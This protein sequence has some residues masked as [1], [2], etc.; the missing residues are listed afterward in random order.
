MK[1]VPSLII[2][3]SYYGPTKHTD[4]DSDFLAVGVPQ[5]ESPGLFFSQT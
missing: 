3:Q 2:T 5:Q 1:A 4:M